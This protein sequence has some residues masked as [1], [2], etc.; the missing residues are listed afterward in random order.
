MSCNELMD[1]FELPDVQLVEGPPTNGLLATSHSRGAGRGSR[2][3]TGGAGE[4]K[5]KAAVYLRLFAVVCHNNRPYANQRT[6]GL[7]GRKHG[8]WT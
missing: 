8:S 6:A 4:A 3:A 1:F 2:A 5:V 7:L